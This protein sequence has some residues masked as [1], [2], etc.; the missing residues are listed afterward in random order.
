MSHSKKIR[1]TL[2][3]FCSGLTDDT[4]KVSSLLLFF[5]Q[6]FSLSLCEFRGILSWIIC[7]HLLDFPQDFPQWISFILV[8]TH[9]RGRGTVK[10]NKISNPQLSSANILD[11]QRISREFMMMKKK[12]AT[13][14]KRVSKSIQNGMSR[15]SNENDFGDSDSC[16][17]TC[18]IYDSHFFVVLLLLLSAGSRWWEWFCMNVECRKRP[19]QSSKTRNGDRQKWG[20]KYSFHQSFIKSIEK[21]NISLVWAWQVAKVETPWSHCV[22]TFSS[23]DM[24]WLRVD[25]SWRLKKVRKEEYAKKFVMRV[26]NETPVKIWWQA[27][28]TLRSREWWQQWR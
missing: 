16:P 5:F 26:R 19:R 1:F 8:T 24:Q 25:F 4:Q 10:T 15:I 27:T 17:R 23:S 18:L 14:Q 28:A 22:E 13:A 11:L 20:R 6:L 12:C 7:Q 2:H 3:Q 21:V 9:K